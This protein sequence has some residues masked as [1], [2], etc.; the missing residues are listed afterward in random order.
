MTPKPPAPPELSPNRRAVDR[1][2]GP[3]VRALLL[4]GEDLT[5]LRDALHMALQGPRRRQGDGERWR[6]LLA[7][8]GDLTTRPYHVP[9]G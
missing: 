4:E 7:Q 9:K 1:G 5:A 3:D 6:A 8:L 2:P